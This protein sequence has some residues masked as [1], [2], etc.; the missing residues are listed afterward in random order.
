MR[1]TKCSYTSFDYLD[2]C[3][4]CGE[5]LVPAKI[6]LNIYSKA[7]EI[8]IGIDGFV[9]SKVTGEAKEMLAG[10]ADKG[11]DVSMEDV[12]REDGEKLETFDFGEDKD[13]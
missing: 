2:R 8:E 11:K 6:K 4:S 7:P 13:R 10:S 5:D 1:C 9:V 3:K 12:L